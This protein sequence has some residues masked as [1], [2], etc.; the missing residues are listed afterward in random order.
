MNSRYYYH[1]LFVGCVVLG[2]AINGDAAASTITY[3]YKGTTSGLDQLGLFAPGGTTLKNAAFTASF[4]FSSDPP[5]SCCVNITSTRDPDVWEDSVANFFNAEP[6][7]FFNASISI[8]PG[9]GDAPFR[10]FD[11][12][13]GYTEDELL[14]LDTPNTVSQSFSAQYF[15][16][17]GFVPGT[18]TT[19]D[20]IDSYNIGFSA[21][22]TTITPSSR[23]QLGDFTGH[24]TLDEGYVA[25]EHQGAL[26]N[27]GPELCLEDDSGV[28]PVTTCYDGP[29]ADDFSLHA[30]SLTITSDFPAGAPEP[31]EWLMMFCG[32][33]VLGSMLRIRRNTNVAHS[34]RDEPNN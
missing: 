27:F 14:S 4:V 29:G 17:L 34:V 11:M 23:T 16:E 19:I 12:T 20:V 10:I 22:G 18:T 3:T 9:T 5:V 2:L 7:A 15:T 28:D 6:L 30:T 13:A 25:L 26:L 21:P 32:L 31:T 8:S 33:G 24:F 1:L